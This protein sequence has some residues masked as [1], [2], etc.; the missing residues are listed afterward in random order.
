MKNTKSQIKNLE[1][2]EA[3]PSD[4]DGAEKILFDI[5]TLHHK[6]AP[7]LFKKPIKNDPLIKEDFLNIIKD[8]ASKYFVAIFDNQIVG[9]VLIRTKER[10]KAEHIV[11][12]KFAYLAELGV[13]KE[14]QNKG[15]GKILANKALMWAKSQ[16]L[17][18]I[19]LNV[20]SFN[21]EAIKFYKHLGFKVESY[22]MNK[23]VKYEK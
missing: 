14:L 8:N 11:P 9:L 7:Y 1:I 4:F 13:K 17:Q 15:I 6:G 10:R 5:A 3:L 2:R 16:D 12:G 23:W 20:R 18:E 21:N 22:K 19:T